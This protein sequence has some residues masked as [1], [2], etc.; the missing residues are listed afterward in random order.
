MTFLGPLLYGATT[1][2]KTGL[3]LISPWASPLLKRPMLLVGF[4]AAL[5][6]L[7]YVFNKAGRQAVVADLARQAKDLHAKDGAENLELVK[8]QAEL[9]KPVERAEERLNEIKRVTNET[10]NTAEKNK[11][12]YYEKWAAQPLPDVVRKR[13]HQR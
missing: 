6:V 4:G 1:V 9:V 5:I 7:P 8:E 2:F 10:K 13:L 11:D 12:T 3:G